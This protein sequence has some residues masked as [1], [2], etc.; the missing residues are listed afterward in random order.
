MTSR[1]FD[2]SAGEGT[3]NWHRPALTAIEIAEPGAQ[4]DG[5]VGS[6][7]PAARGA[8]SESATTTPRLQN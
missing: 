2:P 4:A 6:A 8:K 5:K 3:V 7:N 1:V